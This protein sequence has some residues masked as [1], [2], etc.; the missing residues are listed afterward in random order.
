MKGPYVNRKISR[1]P[2]SLCGLLA[3]VL[4]VTDGCVDANPSIRLDNPELE[5]FLELVLPRRIEIQRYLTKPV[6]FAGGAEADGLEVMLAAHDAAGDFTKLVGTVH[7]EL[8]TMRMASGDRAGERIALWPVEL[9]SKATMVEYWDSLSRFYRFPLKLEGRTLAP[10]RYIL[11]ARLISPTG[12]K[13]F[14][15]YEFSYEA[16]SFRSG[17]AGS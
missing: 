14:D 17:G 13:L 9:T 16:G 10:G 12:T 11:N 15:Q 6:S 7:F 2:Q 8:H 1:Y 3:A 5:A 4:L